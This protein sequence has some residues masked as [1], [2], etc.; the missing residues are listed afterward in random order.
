MAQGILGKL[1]FNKGFGGMM[2]TAF[3][4]GTAATLAPFAMA[5]TGNWAPDETFDNLKLKAQQFG[6]D[7][8]QMIRD[9]QNAE[10]EEDYLAVLAKYNLS[11]FR[12]PSMGF[13]K[14]S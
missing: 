1:W 5:A 13:S 11:G 4:W 12:S 14:E 8:S 6:F 9:I 10:N 7:Y 3:G 2:P